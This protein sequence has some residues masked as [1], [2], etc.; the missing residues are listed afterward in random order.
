MVHTITT[1]QNQ[2]E[3]SVTTHLIAKGKGKIHTA[4]IRPQRTITIGIVAF[5]GIFPT[6]T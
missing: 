2:A 6:G 4:A 3:L 5:K 1:K